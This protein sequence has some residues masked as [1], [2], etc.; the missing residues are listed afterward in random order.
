[1]LAC[2]L[3]LRAFSCSLSWARCAS[4]AAMAGLAV[5]ARPKPASGCGRTRVPGTKACSMSRAA[6]QAVVAEV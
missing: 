6:D 3:L 4:W 5:A 2:L 1:M